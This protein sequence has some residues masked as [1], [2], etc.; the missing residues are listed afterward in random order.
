M[1]DLLNKL[2]LLED[3]DRNPEYM[4]LSDGE[5]FAVEQWVKNGPG[6]VNVEDFRSAVVKF[7]KSSDT[8]YR[9]LTVMRND[10][11]IKVGEIIKSR[12]VA[13]S[14]TTHKSRAMDFVLGARADYAVK[15]YGKI[16]CLLVASLKSAYKIQY[17][18]K[19]AFYASDYEYVIL[20]ET[21]L[22][23]TRVEKSEKDGKEFYI[24][25]CEEE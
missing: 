20:K 2:M 15:R 17:W 6:S 16:R 4:K 13:T 8:F 11:S 9:G 3:F 10:P 7:G 19:Q 25:Y 21:R 18:A 24:V 5:R 22:R 14:F 1:D 23:T 12:N